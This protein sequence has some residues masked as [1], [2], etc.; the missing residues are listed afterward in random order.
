MTD[1]YRFDLP[2]IH[3]HAIGFDR[4]F[5]ELD[6]TFA[7]SRQSAYPPYNVVR[8]D[9]TH[10]LIETAVAG[11]KEGELEVV[12]KDH[13]LT[14]T[15]NKTETAETREYHYQGIS[16][17][18]FSRSF[19]VAEYVEVRSAELKDGILSINL[20]QVIPEESKPKTIAISVAK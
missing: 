20:E 17:R 2:A 16:A 10:T 14:I 3:R 15:G 7:N 6:R 18:H 19:N 12:L 9:D 1:L 8:V 5:T 11:F 13:V 4:L